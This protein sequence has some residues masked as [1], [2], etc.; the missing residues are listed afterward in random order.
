MRRGGFR[1]VTRTARIGLDSLFWSITLFCVQMYFVLLF[2][3]QLCLGCTSVRLQICLGLWLTETQFYV[4]RGRE[5]K[6]QQ[7]GQQTSFVSVGRFVLEAAITAATQLTQRGKEFIKK[8]EN[9]A[10][11][12]CR[13]RGAWCFRATVRYLKTNKP[14]PHFMCECVYFS[15]CICAKN[16]QTCVWCL[17]SAGAS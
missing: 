3:L 1:L 6:H 16:R 4:V 14:L 15:A 12:I 5:H 17:F 13:P 10:C 7:N 8:T 11:L 2:I 9:L